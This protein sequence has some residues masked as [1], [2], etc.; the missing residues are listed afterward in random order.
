MNARDKILTR[1]HY[2]IYKEKSSFSYK[3]FIASDD[4]SNE[5]KYAHGII[6]NIFSQFKKE[7]LIELVCRSPQSFYTLTGVK[8][9]K[10]MTTNYRGVVH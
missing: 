10:G 8:F 5:G 9:E 3:D 4:G 7:G 1:I 2:I 6:R